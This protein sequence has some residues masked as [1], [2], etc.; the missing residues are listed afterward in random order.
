MKESQL[1]MNIAVKILGKKME[2]QQSGRDGVDDLNAF[3]SLYSWI[4]ILRPLVRVP[5]DAEYLV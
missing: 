2:G 1:G 4:N 5:L 3:C